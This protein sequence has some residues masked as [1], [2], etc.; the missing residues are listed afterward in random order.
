LRY[1]PATAAAD[2]ARLPTLLQRP[3]QKPRRL[4]AG[5][6]TC[7]AARGTFANACIK[8][9]KQPFVT[10]PRQC[11]DADAGALFKQFQYQVPTGSTFQNKRTVYAQNGH[12]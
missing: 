9:G 10:M 11:R 2:I 8:R 12:K 6:R 1:E 5:A 7:L 4:F 3:N